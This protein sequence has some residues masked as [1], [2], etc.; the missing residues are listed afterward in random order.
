MNSET[1]NCQN[2]KSDFV[3]EPEDFEFYAKI[4]VPPPTFCPDCR[5][6]RRLS[7][8]N[9]FSLYN[10]KCGLCAKSVVTLYSP[11]SGMN[12]CCN[13]CW[14]SDKW[15]PKDYAV[16]YDF[17]KPFFTQMNELIRRVPVLAMVNDNG[18]A[19]VGCEYT[20]DFSFGKNCYMTFVA[21]H[22]ENYMYSYY[23]IAG[24]DMCDVTSI[25]DTCELCY[26]CIWIQK[27]FNLR[28]SEQCTSCTDSA[29]LYD[30]KDCSDC[31]M[32]AGLRHKKYCYKNEEY[33]KEEYEQILASYRLDTYRGAE[34]A[35]AEFKEFI[36][37][38]PRKFTTN[39]NCFA[40][41]GDLL[42]NG[43]NSKFC[44]NIQKA[45]NDKWVENADTPKDSYDLSVG[46]ELSLCYEGITCDHSNK[47]LFG[48]FSW[49]DMDV[50][51]A[52]HCHSSKY[53]FGC[54]SLR[55]AEYCILNKQYTKEEYEAL[56]PKIIAQMY[57]LPYVDAQNISYKFGEFY[58][59]E[60]SYFGYNESQ[61]Q[62]SFPLSK[63]EVI[64]KG[65][66]WQ[67][68]LQHTVGKETVST[69]NIPDSIHDVTDSITKEILVCTEC[70]RNFRILDQE[71]DLYRR[72]QV[73]IP[74][75][76]FHCRQDAR[77]KKRNPYT[78]WHRQCMKTGCQNEF[79]TT[80]SPD[81]PEI[82]CC[83]SCYNAS[84]V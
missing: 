52:H 57:E 41:T 34:R 51:Y 5:K 37:Q 70:N 50:L 82:V 64:A 59:A 8:R 4:Q 58:P 46:G 26:E 69:E 35:K 21:W 79:E 40:C 18:V 62:A 53:L 66:K 24:K 31:F 33:S 27:C 43:K 30:C 67:D 75:K 16:E 10:Q 72:M 84:V 49:K 39:T 77:L 11:K 68:N 54:A 19:S 28:W 48:I 29:L 25:M 7:W 83:E 22:V 73:P 61:A 81:R 1:R 9:D 44:F 55:N 42:I 14:W 76:C 80:Y 47:N 38:T 17:S 13:R 15:D 65:W 45:E 2:C 56:V 32:S 74:R 23:A 60:L 3:I 71:L 6:Q 36:L 20:N 63:E 12:V 78:L